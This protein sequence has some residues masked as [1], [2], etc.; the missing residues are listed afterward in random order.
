MKDTTG[1]LVPDERMKS[2][3]SSSAVP[4][5]SPI[6]IMPSVCIAVQSSCMPEHGKF[7]QPC[8]HMHSLHACLSA[9]TACR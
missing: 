4:P 2:A 3:A 7:K 8:A 6:M 9:Q 1:L 5:I